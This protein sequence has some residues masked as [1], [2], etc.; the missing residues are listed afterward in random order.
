MLVGSGDDHVSVPFSM[1]GEGG[2]LGDDAHTCAA[3]LPWRSYCLKSLLAEFIRCGTGRLELLSIWTAVLLPRA[4]C[5]RFRSSSGCRVGST[6]RHLS[7]RGFHRVTLYLPASSYTSTSTASLLLLVTRLP[8]CSIFL[9]AGLSY[10]SYAICY[11]I[12]I[13]IYIY[14]IMSM[15]MY[16]MLF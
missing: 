12:Y 1:E 14:V 9:S 10:M 7:T 16:S 3:A 15:F 13:Y 6:A 5:S 8:P 4:L 11:S 2:T